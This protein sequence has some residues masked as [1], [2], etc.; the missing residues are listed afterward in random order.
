MLSKKCKTKK[1]TKYFYFLIF[2]SNLL[3]ASF[4]NSDFLFRLDLS[5]LKFHVP[6]NL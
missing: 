4:L 2:E 5:I 6:S 1:L 3:Q